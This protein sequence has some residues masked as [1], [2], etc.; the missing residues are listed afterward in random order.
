MNT[1]LA[2][3]EPDVSKWDAWTPAEVA[4]LLTGVAAPWYIAAGWAIDLFLG[5]KHREHEDL[6]IAAPNDRFGEVADALVGY[7]IFVITGPREATPLSV[8]GA[9]L[10]THQTWV[11]EPETGRW[12]LDVFRE[13]SD[14]DTW[15]CRRDARIRL[16][17]ARVVE[18][19]AEG[20]PYCRPEIA[21]LFKAKHAHQPKNKDDFAAVLPHLAADSRSW[22]ADA[23]KLAHPGHDWIGA[24]ER[25]SR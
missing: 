9:T 19:T 15:I 11:R 4:E 6:E 21:L 16:P 17:S 14:G 8:A 23:L 25:G 24:L 18:W 22:L 5:G 3:F 13:P 2:A 1:A 12:R 20:I 7:E 10:E